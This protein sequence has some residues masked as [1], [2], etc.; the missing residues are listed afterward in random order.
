MEA[1]CHRPSMSVRLVALGILRVL[2]M[3]FL[4]RNCAV[5]RIC[6]TPSVADNAPKRGGDV[7]VRNPRQPWQSGV[8][9]VGRPVSDRFA[10]ARCAQNAGVYVLTVP[11]NCRG[12]AV[13]ARDIV[14]ESSPPRTRGDNRTSFGM[15][16]AA[17][18]LVTLLGSGLRP[19]VG[20][21]RPSRERLAIVM[22]AL[23]A[24]AYGACGDDSAPGTDAGLPMDAGFEMDAGV[25]PTWDND[26]GPFLGAQCAGCHPWA[27]TYDGTVDK[28]LDGSLRLRAEMGHRM[29][30]AEAATLIDWIDDG[31]LE[32]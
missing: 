30:D 9:V 32:K 12:F 4:Y 27:N 16:D 18:R 20:G 14:V 13:S 7:G 31:Y 22:L 28:V 8:G 2:Q 17:A 23:S 5:R 6:E 10:R 26:V 19:I 11:R 3:Q 29:T 1:P 24:M 25:S 21:G 15:A